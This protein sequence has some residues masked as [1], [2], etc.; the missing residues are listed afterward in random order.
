MPLSAEKAPAREATTVS[1]PIKVEAHAPENN[2]WREI[3]RIES[4]TKTS[5]DFHV[6]RPVEVGQLLLLKMPVKKDLRRFGFD[7]EQYRVWSIVRSCQQT[8]HDDFSNYHVSAAFI[9]QEPP[10]SFRQNPSTIY[11]L[12]KIGENGFWQ[13][14]EMRRGPENR[15]EPRYPIPIEVYIAIYDSQENIVAHEKTVTENISERGASVFSDL[16]LRIGDAVKLIKQSGGFSANAIVR[17]RRVGKDNLPRLHLEFINV[18]FPLEG[19]D[20]K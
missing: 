18:S 20:K 10:E 14:S 13:I 8:R 6:T 16:Q 3:S 9:G 5:A 11:K 17:N 15:R 12:N 4:V 19:I 2:I 1:L 7:K